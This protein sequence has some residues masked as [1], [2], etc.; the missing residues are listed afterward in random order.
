MKTALSMVGLLLVPTVWVGCDGD[1]STE[2]DTSSTGSGAAGAG[3]SGNN[4]GSGAQGGEGAVGGGSATTASGGASTASGGASGGPCTDL[5]EADCMASSPDC[6]PV[7]DDACCPTC[8]PGPCADCSNLEFH[9][10]QAASEAC[11]GMLTCGLVP[12]WA[13]IGAP[14]VCPPITNPDDPYECEATAGCVVAKC[15]PDVN[16]V[17][18][19]CA[20]VNGSS[21]TALCDSLPPSCPAGTTAEADGSCWTGFCIPA[22]V[23]GVF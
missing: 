9:H 15:S 13:C 6:V 3:G 4:G 1:V 16:C 11:D 2:D 12:E 21:C 23:C 7:Y 18:T 19:K 10:C 14:H 17:E 22:A 5:F 20:P 8:E